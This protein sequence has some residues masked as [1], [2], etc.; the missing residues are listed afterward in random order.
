MSESTDVLAWLQEW[1]LA[2]CDG[3]WEHQWGIKIETLD[4]PGWTVRIEIGGT[5]LERCTYSKQ[6]IE[7]SDDDWVETWRSQHAFHAACGPE[8]L[9]EVLTLFRDWARAADIRA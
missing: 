7:R 6:S 8:N 2:Q 1:Y 4:N 3:D 9:A 5:V